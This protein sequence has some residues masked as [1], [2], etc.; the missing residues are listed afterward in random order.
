MRGIFKHSEAGIPHGLQGQL[1]TP[2]RNS[3]LLDDQAGETNLS[4]TQVEKYISEPESSSE[5]FVASYSAET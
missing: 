5:L 1:E 3:E 2:C 4:K